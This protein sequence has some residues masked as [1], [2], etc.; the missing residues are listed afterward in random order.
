MAQR[1]AAPRNSN[2]PFAA[3][4]R[5]RNAKTNLAE[6]DAVE[7]LTAG[8][9][10]AYAASRAY[11]SA[12][13]KAYTRS[14]DKRNRKMRR[15]ANIFEDGEWPIGNQNRLRETLRSNGGTSER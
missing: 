13:L 2:V 3:L 5:L 14:A 9:E 1:D 6:V 11:C 7:V 8:D 10:A 4:G 12:Y 15:H